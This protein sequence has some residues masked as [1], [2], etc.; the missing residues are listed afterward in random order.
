MS[1]KEE[2]LAAIKALS[3]QISKVEA[4]LDKLEG[5]SVSVEGRLAALVQVVDRTVQT[6]EAIDRKATGL[7]RELLPQSQHAALGITDHQPGNVDQL[8]PAREG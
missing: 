7:A 8:P 2:I 3:E 6:V 4:R 5:R 1:D